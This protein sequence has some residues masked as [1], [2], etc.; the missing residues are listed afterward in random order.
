VWEQRLKGICTIYTGAYNNV[1][2]PT[3]RFAAIP[4]RLIR[5]FFVMVSTIVFKEAL[6]RARQLVFK[7]ESAIKITSK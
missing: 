3:W 2:R 5:L 1:L 7:W 6:Q 4:Q